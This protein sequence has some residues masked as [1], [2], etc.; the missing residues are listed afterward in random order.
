MVVSRS[1]GFRIVG[2]MLAFAGQLNPSLD[3]M[4]MPIPARAALG[5]DEEMLVNLRVALAP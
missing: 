3:Q 2:V 4:Q 5:I 1:K